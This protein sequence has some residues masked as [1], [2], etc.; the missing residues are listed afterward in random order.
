MKLKRVLPLT[1]LATLVFS[2]GARNFSKREGRTFNNVTLPEGTTVD[3]KSTRG[4][5]SATFDPNSTTP[6]I[7]SIS[8]GALKGVSIALPVGALSIPLT[9]TVTAGSSPNSTQLMNTL[10]LKDNKITTSGTPVEI[11][12]SA[13][14]DLK[15]PM[16]LSIPLPTA[17]G[18]TGGTINQERMAVIYKIKVAEG[19]DTG[20][21]TGIMP[22]KNLNVS[23][24]NVLFE[25]KFFGW[26]T[27]AE[28]ED[29]VDEPIQTKGRYADQVSAKFFASRSELPPCS[30]TDLYRIAYVGDEETMYYC[31]EDEDWHAIAKSDS[32]TNSNTGPTAAEIIALITQGRQLFDDST[33]TVIGKVEEF[34]PNQ[35]GKISLKMFI[36]GASGTDYYYQ[37]SSMNYNSAGITDTELVDQ[38]FSIYFTDSGNTTCDTTQTMIAANFDFFA[39]MPRVV[40]VDSG[41][42]GW[43]QV[44]TSAAPVSM[45]TPYYSYYSCSS[46]TCSCFS[47]GSTTMGIGATLIPLSDPLPIPFTGSWHV[48]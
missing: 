23:N 36:K 15:N 30:D 26:F 46:G 45:S 24:G 31:G 25:T 9:L 4:G 29:I 18:L 21:F 47:S 6:Q 11:T 5:F 42:I 35:S 32:N 39:V 13:S 1:C 34:L 16:V 22:A 10:G 7:M 8:Q 28:M 19:S 37:N 12:P 48:E 2:C 17:A 38:Y 14:V 43:L 41:S 40:L 44:D 33:G 3:T 27:V 20:S